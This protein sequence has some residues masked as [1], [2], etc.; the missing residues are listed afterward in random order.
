[1]GV[2][3]EAEQQGPKRTVAV[4]VVRG[5][6]F[7]DDSRLRMFQREAETLGRLDKSLLDFKHPALQR[8]LLWKMHDVL[9]TLDKYKPLHHSGSSERVSRRI[10]V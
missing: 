4:K 10:Q 7:V 8:P 1:M 9:D 3:Y 2:V 5:G 6:E